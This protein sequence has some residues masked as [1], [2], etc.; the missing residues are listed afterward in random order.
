MSGHFIIDGKKVPA[1][2]GLTVVNYQDD[3]RLRLR[4]G[5]LGGGNDGARRRTHWIRSIILHTTKGIPGGS[6]Q[7]P[8][9][10]LPGLGPNLGKEFD[11][12]KFWA[13]STKSAGAAL[14]VDFDGSIGQLH[15]LGVEA[16]YHTGNAVNDLSIG[17]EIY[18]GSDAELYSRQLEKVADLVD[19][20]TVQFGIQ[21]QI[22]SRYLGPIDRLDEGGGVDCVGV[23]GHRDITDRRGAGDPG[24]AI[25]QIL[26]ARGYEKFDF[27]RDEDIHV[28][29]ARQR[30]LKAK[31]DGVPG[32]VT[33]QFLREK[34]YRDGLW[35]NGAAHIEITAAAEINR[36]LYQTL[37]PLLGKERALEFLKTV[38]ER[39]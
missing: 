18:Q 28:W 14:V 29:A 26:A 20:L 9:K 36:L 30:L 2:E 25:M 24:D 16:A 34:G 33:T 10:I 35:V 37:I 3:K 13:T 11:V 8:Q 5:Q 19:F 7:R 12:A 22:P 38:A 39:G 31:D 23:F 21:R 1:P 27:Q 4:I 17:I 32:P 6:D 15:D